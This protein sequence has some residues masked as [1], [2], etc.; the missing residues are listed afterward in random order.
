MEGGGEFVRQ[1]LSLPKHVESVKN[2]AKGTA[3]FAKKGRKD[4]DFVCPPL[5]AAV[6]FGAR[7]AALFAGKLIFFKI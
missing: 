6:G 4:A 2:R 5:A 3:F 1:T 7:R